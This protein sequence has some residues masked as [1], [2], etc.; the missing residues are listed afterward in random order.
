M[1]EAGLIQSAVDAAIAH[2]KRSGKHCIHRMVLRVGALSGVDPE[3]L[4]FAFDA[5]AAGTMAESAT[6][7]L[8]SESA[9]AGCDFCGTEFV[10]TDVF[11]ECPGCGRPSSSIL[12]GR[13]VTLISLEAS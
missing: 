11:C 5:A 13:D 10:A 6:L 1:H 7:E 3:A 8:E 2:A 12:R 9:A 4:S